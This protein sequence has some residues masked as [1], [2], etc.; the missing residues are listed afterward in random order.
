MFILGIRSISYVWEFPSIWNCTFKCNNP[1]WKNRPALENRKI[2]LSFSPIIK[3]IR[4]SAFS[5]FVAAILI[6]F[7]M[8]IFHPIDSHDLSTDSK[9]MR[10]KSNLWILYEKLF[11]DLKNFKFSTFSLIDRMEVCDILRSGIHKIYSLTSNCL[12]GGLVD[13]NYTVKLS[14]K[15]FFL[16]CCM[17]CREHQKSTEKLE[18]NV[19]QISDAYLK[20]LMSS[21]SFLRVLFALVN[22]SKNLEVSRNG[23]YGII[24]IR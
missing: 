21:T 14:I 22:G 23:Y 17:L 4:R 20:M 5:L 6:T 18:K 3:Q 2:K 13:R 24:S 1:P 19:T 7:H 16:S 8:W 11:F 12:Q 10:V 9:Q 15:K